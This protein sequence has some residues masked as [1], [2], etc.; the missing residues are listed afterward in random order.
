MLETSSPTIQA[1]ARVSQKEKTEAHHPESKASENVLN[2]L[3][4]T[5]P[6]RRSIEAQ[7]GIRAT[8]VNPLRNNRGRSF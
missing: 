7:I 2:R 6:N 1:R 4:K 8:A 3:E 5:K